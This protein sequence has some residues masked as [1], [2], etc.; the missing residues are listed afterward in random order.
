M[1]GRGLAP[2]CLYLREK[3]HIGEKSDNNHIK[4]YLW[5]SSNGRTCT[6]SMEIVKVLFICVVIP[7]YFLCPDHKYLDV[8]HLENHEIFAR[9]LE[10][11][12]GLP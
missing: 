11:G 8:M 1:G 6:S 9:L 4:V 2:L 12:G 3:D 10:T 7:F 5:D